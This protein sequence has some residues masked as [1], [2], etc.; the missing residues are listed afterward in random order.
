[1]SEWNRFWQT[2]GSR[3]V[4]I[5]DFIVESYFLLWNGISFR[6]TFQ[7]GGKIDSIFHGGFA[8]AVKLLVEWAKLL[9]AL[10]SY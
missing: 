9:H 4:Q 6:Y 5:E 2:G 1:M 3:S 7:F 10:D 8:Q